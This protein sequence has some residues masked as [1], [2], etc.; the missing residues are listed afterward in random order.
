LE[1]SYAS[2]QESVEYWHHCPSRRR[3]AAPSHAGV[4]WERLPHLLLASLRA[5]V[6]QPPD[7]RS[8]WTRAADIHMASKFPQSATSEEEHPVVEEGPSVAIWPVRKDRTVEISH[9]VVRARPKHTGLVAN[10]ANG[11]GH[12]RPILGPQ[13]ASH[14][15][16]GLIVLKGDFASKVQRAG[17]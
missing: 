5:P 16:L 13:A 9:C 10:V 12:T 1:M 8:A 7:R 3:S 2:A 11:C 14:V 17:L 15:G 4:G 6:T